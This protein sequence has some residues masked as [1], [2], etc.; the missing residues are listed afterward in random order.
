MY[1]VLVLVTDTDQARDMS[2]VALKVELTDPDLLR[3]VK[4]VKKHL[5]TVEDDN[6]P[7]VSIQDAPTSPVPTPTGPIV[8]GHT[9]QAGF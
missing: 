2:K 6:V 8:P 3:L 9:W 4:R 1:K 5:E 7:A